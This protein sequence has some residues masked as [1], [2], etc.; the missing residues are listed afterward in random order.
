MIINISLEQRA[1][2]IRRLIL[3]SYY[4]QVGYYKSYPLKN[5]LDLEIKRN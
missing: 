1:I 4:P 2:Y 5:N 3:L